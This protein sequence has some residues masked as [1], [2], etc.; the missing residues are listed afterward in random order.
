MP[1][2]AEVTSERVGSRFLS[3][4]PMADRERLLQG[5]RAVDYE[6]G[7]S[8]V[9]R[10]GPI[11]KVVFPLTCVISLVTSTESGEL[12]ELA[13]FG[14]EGMVGATAALG[15]PDIG[16]AEAFCQVEGTGL[17]LPVERF[18]AHM[19]SSAA[20]EGLV[21]RYLLF[22]AGQLAQTALCNTMHPLAERC[23]RWLLE[24]HDRVGRKR[25]HLT[26]EYLAE[27]LAVRRASVT[28]AASILQ[29]A[30]I[31]SYRRGE[32]EVHDRDALEAASCECYRVLQGEYERLVVLN[33][34][35]MSP[36]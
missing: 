27:M 1:D 8:L 33:P 10:R 16:N 20:M 6:L 26:Q 11:T 35:A 13:T 23:A 3:L 36:S 34:V 29:R 17:E 5:T 21:K 4:L 25:F 12:M 24:T 18:L 28:V 30:G 15:A 7:D 2:V 19:R 9:R 14:R 22:S 32:L 31:I